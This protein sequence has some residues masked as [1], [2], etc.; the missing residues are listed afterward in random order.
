MQ[1]F[2]RVVDQYDKLRKRNAFLE[3][4][5]KVPMFENNLQEFDEARS[6][7][8]PSHPCCESH[9]ADRNPCCTLGRSPRN[10]LRNMKPVRGKITLGMQMEGRKMMP[11]RHRSDSDWIIFGC[12]SS[13]AFLCPALSLAP[14]S[15]T[16]ADNSF[17]YP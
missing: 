7:D 16:P 9:L 8:F 14:P 12:T 4:Y 11:G 10:L 1:L 6:V 13:N 15:H 5:K 3:Q 17:I 2:K